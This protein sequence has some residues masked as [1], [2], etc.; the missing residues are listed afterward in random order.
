[1]VTADPL[2]I[3]RDL[4]RTRE[5]V[6]V[7]L[8][9]GFS[10]IVD[11]LRLRDAWHRWTRWF[12]R[13]PA[14][15]TRPLRTVERVR[16]VLESLGP[17]FV[18]FGQVLSTR[19][20]LIPQAMLTELERLQE[21]VPPFSSE[22]ATAEIERQ[23]GRTVPELFAEFDSVPL[24]A[25]SL[26]QVH[27]ARRHDGRVVAVKIRR[28]GVERDVERDLSLMEQL[29]ALLAHRVPEL[30]VF[31]PVGL[32]QHF[33]RTIRR[34][35]NFSREARTMEEMSRWFADDSR[36]AIP[37]VDWDVTSESVLTMDFV[38]ALRLDDGPAIQAAGLSP[39]QLAQTGAELF[40][41]QVFQFGLFHGDPHPGNLRVRTDGVITLL[42]FGMVGMIERGLRDRIIDLFQSIHRQDLDAACQL[43]M[44]I[45]EVRGEMDESLLR[46]D[47]ADFLANYYGV[48]LD[49]LNVGRLLTDFLAILSRHSI[50]CP[51]SLL[52]LVRA[53]VTLEGVG[54][55][56][57]PS[58]N[59]AGPLRPFAEQLIADRYS[60]SNL[61]RRLCDQGHT[62][63][64]VA[65]RLPVHVTHAVEKLARDD[66]R[67]HL[68]HRGLDRLILELERASNRL[69]V[70][71]VVASLIVASAVILRQ[72]EAT[73]WI[74]LPIYVL[75][76]LLAIWLVYGIFR[77]GQL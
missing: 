68:E 18:K 67:V 49:R 26:G 38:D 66:L 1:M 20:D 15:P 51:A 33:S 30:R 72:G 8:N 43:V 56:L 29:A 55:R 57:D 31:D 25:G 69:V 65:N 9:H 28:P 75:S 76:S 62:L 48:P 32:V 77:S 44:L 41:K 46:V 13:N 60:P 64:D 74:S 34:E 11:R 6:A 19:P 2:R 36:V 21:H 27:R 14:P 7:L 61:W 53:T 54:R 24:A 4:A 59:L 10:D 73:S 35:L 40:L 5:I 58:F 16:L 71:L 47:L 63:A 50:R 70:G 12:Q 52:L 22:T 3:F 45:G 37:R 39:Q 23:F 17:T 42:D